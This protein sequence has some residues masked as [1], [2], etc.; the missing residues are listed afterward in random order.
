M[1]TSALATRAIGLLMLSDHLIDALLLLGLILWL[2]GV[3]VG[4][5]CP[6]DHGRAGVT[7]HGLLGIIIWMHLEDRDFGRSFLGSIEIGFPV[8]QDV[9]FLIL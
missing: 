2:A 7:R 4:F 1:M 6:R 5:L 9:C 8:S 3:G